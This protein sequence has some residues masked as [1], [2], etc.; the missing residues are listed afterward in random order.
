MT[1]RR[2]RVR[3]DEDELVDAAVD[4]HP[5]RR[6]SILTLDS[7]YLESRKSFLSLRFGLRRVFCGSS[8]DRGDKV[9][10]A[11]DLR[12][13]NPRAEFKLRRN[14]T[15]RAREG[16]AGGPVA[17]HDLHQ[18]GRRARGLSRDRDIYH[19]KMETL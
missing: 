8:R 15:P 2:L 5:S 12:G 7:E 11:L 13:R 16:R 19:F 3:A 14:W 17:V 4:L 9:A 6:G 1:V 10:R 18:V